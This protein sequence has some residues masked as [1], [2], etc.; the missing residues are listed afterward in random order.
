[1]QNCKFRAYF[2]SSNQKHP[3][4]AK[5]KYNINTYLAELPAR[6]TMK[7]ITKE[8][9]PHKITYDTFNRDRK[10]EATESTSIP[11]DRLQVYAGLFGCTIDDL[12]NTKKKVKPIVKNTLTKKLGIKLK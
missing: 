4:M 6:I 9:Q 7:E 8:L 3:E 2:D 1:M 5:L 12:I 11:S 10:I